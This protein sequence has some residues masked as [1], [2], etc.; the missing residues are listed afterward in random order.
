MP[1]EEL[2]EAADLFLSENGIFAVIIPFK[3]EENFALAKDMSC[4]PLKSLV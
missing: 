2:I 4:I 3:E 1:F